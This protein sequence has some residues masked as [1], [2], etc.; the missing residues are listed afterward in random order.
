MNFHKIWFFQFC[1][2]SQYL[3]WSSDQEVK[4]HLKYPRFLFPIIKNVW[5]NFYACRESKRVA[6][7]M[8]FNIIPEMLLANTRFTRVQAHAR[9]CGPRQQ[10]LIFDYLIV[11]VRQKL[12]QLEFFHWEATKIKILEMSIFIVKLHIAENSRTHP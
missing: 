5:L 10:T 4:K 11:I 7:K 12:P 2:Q 9:L 3:N 1:I 6:N 8:F